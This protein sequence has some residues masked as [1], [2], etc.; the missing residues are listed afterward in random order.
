MEGEIIRIDG[1]ALTVWRETVSWEGRRTAVLG[2]F[3]A[4]STEAAANLLAETARRLAA[5]G[6]EALVGPM[7]GDTWAA[8]RLVVESTGRAPFLMEPPDRPELAAALERAGW[9]PIAHYQSAEGPL[10]AAG[11]APDPPPGVVLRA[12]DPNRAEQE[13]TAMH[14]VSVEAFASAFLYRPISLERF[15]AMYR[16]VVA[17]IDP[18]LVIM[19]EDDQGRLL[20]YLFAV[21][22]LAD[23]SPDRAVI[24]KTYASLRPGL[25][26]AM[27]RRFTPRAAEAGYRRVIHALMHEDNLSA[28]HSTALGATTFRRYALWGLTL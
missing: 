10:P 28:R 5:E 11:A 12:F 25:G 3:E 14:R 17:H 1:A 16:P 21:P 7:D 19:A 15:L 9:R 26:S 23:P 22:D 27:M 2:A 24:V 18:G 20:G 6:F 13:L 4:S 8:Y